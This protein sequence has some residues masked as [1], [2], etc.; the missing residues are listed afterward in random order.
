MTNPSE[1]A[2]FNRLLTA[3]HPEYQPWYFLVE[4][5]NKDPVRTKKGWK[6]PDSRLS[7]EKATKMIQCGLNIG[8]AGTDKDMLV[9]ID[10]D[11][12]T[13]IPSNEIKP[14]LSARSRSRTGTHHFYFATSMDA[15]INIPTEKYGEIRSY[16]QYVVAPGSYVPCSQQE[17]D[18]MH[19]DQQQYSG[20]YTVEKATIARNITFNE[21]PSVFKT[22]MAEKSK[23][24]EARKLDMRT[25][26]D[27]SGNK[28]ALYNLTITDVLGTCPT[29]DRFP[30]IFHDSSTN[31]N[32][33]IS[34]NQVHCW[35]H[36]V[37]L[38]PLRALAV[39]AGVDSCMAAGVSHKHSNAGDSSINL[40]DGKT[41]FT[42]WK[43]AKE[44]GMIPLTDPIPTVALTWFAVTNGNCTI[45][46]LV[47]GWK[48]PTEVYCKAK[49]A[50]LAA[51]L[52]QHP[53]R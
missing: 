43:Y 5:G 6:H 46:D 53:T 33:S 24:D 49:D 9:I 32:T 1:F 10:V 12:E 7:P 29:H 19:P 22:H 51:K 3:G 26:V 14:T 21:F 42:L 25:Q 39:L 30:S 8:I 31:S 48:L 38:T 34:D 11:D 16:W 45:T 35:R 2:K 20:Q 40:E 17:K 52:L 44:Q 28:S 15:K 23:R 50:L 4:I 41:V 37:S 18:A 36:N 47:D 13:N 27:T